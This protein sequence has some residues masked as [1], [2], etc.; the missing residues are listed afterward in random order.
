IT[1]VGA[2]KARSIDV[3]IVAATHKDLKMMVEAGTFREDLYYRLFN[4]TLDTKPLRDRPEDI[5]P[6]VAQFTNEVCE[7]NHFNRSFNRSCLELFRTY[8]WPG[9]VRELRS[10]V[11]R[12]LLCAESSVVRKEHLDSMFFKPQSTKPI[13]LDE[14]D[15]H[16]EE[17]KKSHISQILRAA[18]SR[19]EAA[20][21]LNIAQ[22]G[23]QYFI[24]KWN[25]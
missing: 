3:R 19:A 5:E 14:I 16:L 9:N 7:R 22:N 6:L 20:R 10:T 4:L 11:E 21:K 25:L 15:A 17:L 8:H 12:H 13:T 2:N 18:P 1:P 24:K 23:L